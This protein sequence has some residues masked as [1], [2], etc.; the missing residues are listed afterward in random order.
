MGNV[1]CNWR[2]P[3]LKLQVEGRVGQNP[4]CPVVKLRVLVT[5]DV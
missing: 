1:G 4:M 5:L 2:I 3:S